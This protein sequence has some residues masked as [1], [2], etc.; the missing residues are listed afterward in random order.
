MYISQP[1][2]QG[3]PANY[4][5]SGDSYSRTGFEVTGVQPSV[6]SPLG[7]PAY[8][9]DTSANGP[10]WVNYLTVRY[11]KS[12]LLT[13][14]FGTSGATLNTSI[15]AGDGCSVQDELNEQYLP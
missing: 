10:N 15:V 3:N 12:V 4:P 14:N 7:N 13:Y 1:H 2:F 8:P 5:S 6:S 9:G 11:N